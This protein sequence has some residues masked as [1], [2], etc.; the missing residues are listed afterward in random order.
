M[1]GTLQNL[2][3]ADIE[4]RYPLFLKGRGDLITAGLLILSEFMQWS[5]HDEI[6]VSTGGIRHG[7]LLDE[8]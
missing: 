6:I 1:V 3:A 4:E 8:L 5:G 2:T 7:I